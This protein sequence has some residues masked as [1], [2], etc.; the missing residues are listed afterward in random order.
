MKKLWK[1]TN[2]ILA[3]MLVV[4]SVSPF[5]YAAMAANTN[6]SFDVRS[7]SIDVRDA[8]N[9]IASTASNGQILQLAWQMYV[10]NNLFPTCQRQ[11]ATQEAQNQLASTSEGLIAIAPIC[12]E[13]LNLNMESMSNDMLNVLNKFYAVFFPWESFAEVMAATQNM[14]DQQLVDYL[15]AIVSQEDKARLI[16]YIMTGNLPNQSCVL[17]SEDTQ[18]YA[19]TRKAYESAI[20]ANNQSQASQ[21]FATMQDIKQKVV[22]PVGSQQEFASVL[23]DACT[24]MLATLQSQVAIV[25]QSSAVN[26]DAEVQRIQNAITEIASSSQCLPTT[27]RQSINTTP[28]NAFSQIQ[29]IITFQSSQQTT[30]LPGTPQFC[31][32]TANTLS[33]QLNNATLPT[34]N[35]LVS[36]IEGIV[37][38]LN[39]E[40]V[41]LANMIKNIAL[42]TS[43]KKSIDLWINDGPKLMSRLFSALELY[44]NDILSN[45]TIK[46]AIEKFDTFG[47]YIDILDN[48]S[49]LWYIDS[50]EVFRDMLVRWETWIWDANQRTF[51][52][53][54]QSLPWLKVIA[55]SDQSNNNDRLLEVREVAAIQYTDIIENS[56]RSEKTDP[57]DPTIQQLSQ[58]YFGTDSGDWITS[59]R[60]IINHIWHQIAFDDTKNWPDSIYR[61]ATTNRYLYPISNNQDV[62]VV[63]IDTNGSYYAVVVDSNNNTLL[64]VPAWSYA[65]RGNVLDV[66]PSA[67]AV[68]SHRTVSTFPTQLDAAFFEN[69]QLSA[70]IVGSVNWPTQPSPITAVSPIKQ[71]RNIKENSELSYTTSK[72]T[73]SDWGKL[74]DDGIFRNDYTVDPR[75]FE[76]GVLKYEAN[77]AVGVRQQQETIAVKRSGMIPTSMDIK[78]FLRPHT[79]RVV[80]DRVYN[81]GS[82]TINYTISLQGWAICNFTIQ[83]T[84][85]YQGDEYG[86][87]VEQEDGPITAASMKISFDGY[88]IELQTNQ[89]RQMVSAIQSQWFESVWTIVNQYMNKKNIS[90]FNS[91]FANLRVESAD[92]DINVM[93]DYIVGNFASDNVMTFVEQII[94]RIQ[95]GWLEDIFNLFG[96]DDDKWWDTYPSQPLSVYD[97]SWSSYF[98]EI[99]QASYHTFS[100]AYAYDGN[101]YVTVD[102]E[103][104]VYVEKCDAELWCTQDSYTMTQQPTGEYI[105]N[106]DSS[107]IDWS[108]SVFVEA[109]YN[110][111]F[112][113]HD[114][115]RAARSATLQSA[116]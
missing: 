28:S 34:I 74:Q 16:S 76:D 42:E 11:Q 31:A 72:L 10:I 33:T 46:K 103:P 27:V 92:K 12:Q 116:E 24:N 13:A 95:L 111:E 47:T 66:S 48:D 56:P 62:A 86:M 58:W 5:S 60:K 114:F 7:A 113:R 55:S 53:A 105:L 25:K 104:I 88:A 97:A 61:A 50:V 37:P 112:V 106:I 20:L 115:I 51:N 98:D 102:R 65:M 2:L 89:V 80:A 100:I 17:S 107:Q 69:G 68:L 23:T 87:P 59:W 45:R 43:N 38:N 6:V 14:S 83:G 40:K 79:L 52:Q 82:N 63:L 70:A 22:C 84:V 54:P 81:N 75:Y 77:T 3:T 109:Y 26:R 96:G 85:T 78:L 110:G 35:R 1:I 94:D 4:Q 39:T 8:Y 36:T 71:S 41:Q 73:I 44:I 99:K 93:I 32:T 30:A 49:I 9:K 90:I 67:K 57:I 29:Q 19:Q 64:P 21:L 101:I 15:N 108:D 91:P 18:T